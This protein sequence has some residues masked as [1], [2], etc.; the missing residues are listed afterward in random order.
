MECQD[1]DV[2]LITAV[3]G[4]ACT[5]V[6]FCSAAAAPFALPAGMFF[7][8]IDSANDMEQGR[9]VGNGYRFSRGVLKLAAL[10]FGLSAAQRLLGI[11]TARAAVHSMS[12]TRG[13]LTCAEGAENDNGVKAL[14]G[15]CSAALGGV[16]VADDCNKID[17]RALQRKVISKFD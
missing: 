6:G 15:V 3:L 16:Q 1:K 17:L 14:G 13:L 4:T 8:L 11:G 5:A 9:Y 10:P 2:S 7:A 12:A